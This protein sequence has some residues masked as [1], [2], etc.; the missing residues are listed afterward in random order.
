[1]SPVFLFYHGWGFNSQCWEPLSVY[2]SEFPCYFYD[3]GY[4][5]EIKSCE[6]IDLSAFD[7]IGVGHSLGFLKLHSSKIKFKAL[8][9][10]QAFTHFLGIDE[11]IHHARKRELQGMINYFE[12]DPINTLRS[13]YQRCGYE[14]RG[15][16]NIN[17]QKLLHDLKQL[18]KP[19]EF[20]SDVPTLIIGATND[21][22]VPPDIIRDNFEKLPNT[23]IIMHN[24]SSHCVDK[25]DCKRLQ[26]EIME[27]VS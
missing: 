2:F 8:I 3:R 11:K 25:L 9:G 14:Y 12:H 27:F 18:L 21:L 6:E 16:L 7:V 5:G 26:Q 4:F 10:I 19:H 20:S 24:A 13:F 23:K 22:I 17:Q 15:D 1:M